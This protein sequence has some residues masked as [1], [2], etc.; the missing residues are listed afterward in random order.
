MGVHATYCLICGLPIQ[1]DHYV[2]TARNDLWAI[3][4]ADNKPEGHFPFTDSH[5]W[6]L[7]GVAVNPEE[8]PFY[9]ACEDGR[10]LADGEDYYVGR[11]DEDYFAMHRYCWEAAGRPRDHI[12]VYHYK[13]AFET[14][15][16]SRYQG[17]LFDFFACVRDGEGW[18]LEDPERP[19]GKKNR[20][21]ISRLLNGPKPALGEDGAIRPPANVEELLASDVWTLEYRQ[22]EEGKFDFWRFRDNVDAGIDTSG[23]P[24]LEW[25]IVRPGETPVLELER[26]ERAFYRKIQESKLAVALAT[27][28]IQGRY[29]F[30]L[31]ARDHQA[32][33][34]ELTAGRPP[35]TLELQ[36]ENEPAWTGYFEEF[37]A[38]FPLIR[39]Y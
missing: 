36:F 6:L 29:Y 39:G 5:D 25:V 23:Y 16:L 15:F 34:K 20:E 28:T 26:F 10:L 17:Q 4:R 9:G 14:T 22:Y 8:G 3:Y 19:A 35:G 18:L 13:Y 30:V 7:Q 12:S 31:Q 27:V 11:G 21:R 38:R 24:H 37:H 32:F 33:E 1:H 2:A